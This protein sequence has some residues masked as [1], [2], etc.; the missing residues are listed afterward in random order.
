MS[1]AGF[2]HCF[3]SLLQ[4]LAALILLLVTHLLLC[5]PSQ[6][7]LSEKREDESALSTIPWNMCVVSCHPHLHTPPWL[8]S[9]L[10]F[11]SPGWERFKLSLAKPADKSR[12]VF[13][14]EQELLAHLCP[15]HLPILCK[16]WW[17]SECM[18]GGGGK[19]SLAAA[20][21]GRPSAARNSKWWEGKECPGASSHP[22][23]MGHPQLGL[24]AAP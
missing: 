20:M 14:K 24:T 18:M 1:F 16:H 5:P 6:P 7:R 17:H 15:G 3:F 22:W 4:V 11:F 8:N 12:L 13:R 19:P 10:F 23:T 21:A 9:D 2:H